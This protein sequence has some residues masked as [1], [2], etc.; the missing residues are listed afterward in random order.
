MA[1][2]HFLG[3][4][5]GT[6]PIEGRHHLAFVIEVN[7]VYYW[8]D[9][10]ENC[11]RNAHLS[12]IDIL[13]VKAV[14]I[15]HTH[16]DHVGGLGN[17]FW[18]IRKLTTISDRRPID[19]RIKLFI[20][21]MDSWNGI[22]KMLQNTECNFKCDFDIET[23]Q[24]KDGVVYN[25]ENIKV[26]AVHNHHLQSEE[27]DG[28]LSYSYI[29]EINGKK[30]VFSGDVRDMQDL[31]M[32][33]GEGCDYLLVETGHHKI[34]DVGAFVNSKN[35]GKVMFVHHGREIINDEDGAKEKIKTFNCLAVICFDSMTEEI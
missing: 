5:S 31:D 12:G 6:E 27:E 21:N 11:S 23:E 17:L 25:D 1:T 15:S 29:I 4:C 2:I 14:F 33:I 18:N 28:W 7:G 10:G 20:P 24:T 26:S 3:T 34:S 8:F 32:S 16:M 13:K 35:V 30:V 19:K 22:Y 9:A